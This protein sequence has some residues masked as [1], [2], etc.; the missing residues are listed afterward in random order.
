MREDLE[1]CPFCGGPA[2]V[3]WCQPVWIEE[4]IWAVE[5]LT[6][7][8]GVFHGE[9]QTREEAIA[10]WNTRAQPPPPSSQPFQSV[11]H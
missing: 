2:D 5:C 6:Y 7:D 8:C 10:A 3:K 1:P 11:T 4:W 9:S